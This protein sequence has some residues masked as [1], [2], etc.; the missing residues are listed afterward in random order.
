MSGDDRGSGTNLEKNESGTDKARDIPDEMVGGYPHRF[1]LE[2]VK[3]KLSD[4]GGIVEIP[5]QNGKDQPDARVIETGEVFNTTPVRLEVKTSTITKP[6]HIINRVYEAADTGE[7]L[8]F[9]LCPEKNPEGSP[10]DRL[11]GI[12]SN[13]ELAHTRRKDGGVCLYNSRKHLKTTDGGSVLLPRDRKPGEWVLD[14]DS[15]TLWYQYGADERLYVPL[16]S[17]DERPRVPESSVSTRVE[18]DRSSGEYVVT[19]G[20]ETYVYDNKEGV[21]YDYQHIREPVIPRTD[22][23]VSRV[24][25]ELEYLIVEGGKVYRCQHPRRQRL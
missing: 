20:E 7:K 17:G 13:P 22:D 23:A 10:T 2:I 16:P 18:Y 14:E 1:A 5:T 24:L 15:D 12:L 6:A 9:V 25:D 4:N 8:V 3:E 19:D 11:D 21:K